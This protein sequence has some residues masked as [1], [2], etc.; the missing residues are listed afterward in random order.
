M[1]IDMN[2]FQ[3]KWVLKMK[4]LQCVQE[5]ECSFEKFAKLIEDIK[6]GNVDYDRL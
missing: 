1:L 3:R 6:A 5:N 2:L 4:A